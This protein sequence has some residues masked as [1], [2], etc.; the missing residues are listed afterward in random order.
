VITLSP[1]GFSG[2]SDSKRSSCCAE[3]PGLIPGSGRSP[4]EG[5]GTPLAFLPVEFHGQRILAVTVHGIAKSWT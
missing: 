5:N 1:P 3:D 2:G 4:G